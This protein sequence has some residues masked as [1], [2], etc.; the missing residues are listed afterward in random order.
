MPHPPHPP[1]PEPQAVPRPLALELRVHGVH[2]AAPEK[3]LDDPRTV[4]VTGDATAAVFRRTADAEAEA[5]PERY[6]GRPVVEAYCW[7]RLTSGNGSRALWLLLLPFMVVNL[8][9]WARPAVPDGA[10]Q[11]RA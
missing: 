9:H 6:A 7:S 3:L 10:P 8:A 2:G 1:A 4:R 5:H 11:P